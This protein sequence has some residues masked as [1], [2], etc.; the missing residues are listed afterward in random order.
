MIAKRYH[1]IPQ[2]YI[3]WRK[4]YIISKIYHIAL[5]QYIISN[6]SPDKLEFIFLYYY[7]IYIIMVKMLEKAEDKL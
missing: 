1:N 7:K 3:M 6:L 2:G 5:W 4:P